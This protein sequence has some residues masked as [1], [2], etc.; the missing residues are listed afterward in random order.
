M[1][2]KTSNGPKNLTTPGS[3]VV[4]NFTSTSNDS[5]S[6]GLPMWVKI[7]IIVLS[8]L[9]IFYLYRYFSKKESNET[10]GMYVR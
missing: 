10:Y 3:K 4:E 6:K 1:Y 9:V 5:S 8:L 2:I 7:L